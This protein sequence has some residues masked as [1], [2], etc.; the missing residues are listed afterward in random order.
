VSGAGRSGAGLWIIRGIYMEG[1][2]KTT[3]YYLF[4]KI[5]F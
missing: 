1:L 3:V 2:R 5:L 4:T